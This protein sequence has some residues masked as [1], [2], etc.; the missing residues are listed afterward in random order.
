L[1]SDKRGVSPIFAISRRT[2]M[3]ARFNAL[4]PLSGG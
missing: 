3:R 2:R 1:A 4:S